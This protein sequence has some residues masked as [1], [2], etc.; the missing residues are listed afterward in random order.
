M[1]FL[2]ES[3]TSRNREGVFEN[4]TYF[5]LLLHCPS[6]R[7]IL[8]REPNSASKNSESLVCFKGADD[9]DEFLGCIISIRGQ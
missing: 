9:L 1:S 7:T 3:A 2:K 6:L 5:N 4:L 8:G